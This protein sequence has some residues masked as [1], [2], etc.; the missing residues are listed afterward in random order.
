MFF[1]MGGKERE[2]VGRV[3]FVVAKTGVE[4]AGLV[5]GGEKWERGGWGGGDEVLVR[6]AVEIRYNFV[7]VFNIDLRLSV[8]LL[9][10]FDFG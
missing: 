6:V 2:G 7:Y 1:W 3:E 9:Y 4:E 10:I 5:E 8:G